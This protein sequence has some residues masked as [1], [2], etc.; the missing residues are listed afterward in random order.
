MS[1]AEAML[2]KSARDVQGT[3]EVSCSHSLVGIRK[4]IIQVERIMKSFKLK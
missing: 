1:E 4:L 3:A 2:R